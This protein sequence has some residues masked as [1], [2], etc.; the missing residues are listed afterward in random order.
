MKVP[1]TAV[2]GPPKD[3]AAPPTHLPIPAPAAQPAA[4]ASPTA[5]PVTNEPLVWTDGYFSFN[6]SI[7][8]IRAFIAI[9]S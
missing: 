2:A 8:S 1:N 5:P 6:T 7:E 9:S 4:S 3:P